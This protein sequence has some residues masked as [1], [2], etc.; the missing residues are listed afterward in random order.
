MSGLTKLP[1]QRT[2]PEFISEIG[3]GPTLR[4]RRQT[5]VKEGEAEEVSG[6][7][8][9]KVQLAHHTAIGQHQRSICGICYATPIQ[10]DQYI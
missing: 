5:L 9:N 6:A 7:E 1:S 2:T 8:Q 3:S 4:Q 10:F